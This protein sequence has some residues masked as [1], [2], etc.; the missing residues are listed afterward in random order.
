MITAMEELNRGAAQTVR[1]RDIASLFSGVVPA[2]LTPER[3]A[4]SGGFRDYRVVT[5]KDVALAISPVRELQTIRAAAEAVRKFE[6][7][8]ADVV[9][10]ARG[11]TVRA[12]VVTVEQDGALLGPNLVGIRLR[13]RV[14]LPELLASFIRHPA[15]QA[16]LLDVTAGS[17]TPGMTVTT[18]SNLQLVLQPF[19]SQ[20]ELARIMQLTEAYQAATL[21]AAGLRGEVVSELVHIALSATQS[22]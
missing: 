21:R 22:N 4:V 17:V 20:H 5:L 2:R 1:L 12:A 14:L 6:L 10:T 8:V 3:D 16:K 19:A 7:R 18:A 11:S 13:E 9:A 15:T